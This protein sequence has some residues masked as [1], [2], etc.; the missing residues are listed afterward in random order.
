MGALRDL[1]AVHTLLGSPDLAGGLSRHGRAAVVGA[2]RQVLDATRQR[3]RR[4]E[5]VD[6]RVEALA[7][8]VLAALRRER[9]ALRPVINATGV[10]LH[11]GLGRSPL[12]P[13]AIEAVAAAAKGYC[14]LEFDLEKALDTLNEEPVVKVVILRGAGRA[15]CAGAY[16]KGQ[17]AVEPIGTRLTSPASFSTVRS[18][19]TAGPRSISVS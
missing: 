19:R 12:A 4:G 5:T 10:L 11:T 9:P 1:P 2:I 6:A 16:V 14:S 3:L 7:G 8:E 13:E 18:G 17:T 15:F